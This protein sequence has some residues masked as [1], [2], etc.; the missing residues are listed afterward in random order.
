MFSFISTTNCL[1]K[2]EKFIQTLS[3]EFIITSELIDDNIS[4]ILYK[5]GDSMDLYDK[6]MFV[7]GNKSKSSSIAKFGQNYM[8]K[9]MSAER[10]ADE[11]Y[12]LYQE[13]MG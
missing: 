2:S 6:M 11:I 3:G 4:G 8:F 10:N 9:N 5:Q 12:G 13:I 7:I 1:I